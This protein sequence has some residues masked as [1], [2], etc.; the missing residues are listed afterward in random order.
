MRTAKILAFLMVVC[1]VPACGTERAESSSAATPAAEVPQANPAAEEAP[2]PSAAYAIHEW[3]F[4]A[5]HYA[6]DE[7]A[8]L[9]TSTAPAAEERQPTPQLSPG[10][11][12][13]HAGGKPVLYVHLLGE[14]E[15]AHF[16]AS[17][18]TAGRFVEEWPESENSTPT[19]LSWEVEARRSACSAIGRYP[20]A[21]SPHCFGIAD[22]Y[23]EAAELAHYETQDSACLTVASSNG[24]SERLNHLFY[25]AQMPGDLPLRVSKR[26]D[27]F[28]VV[29]S[30]ALPGRLMRIRRAD[31]A[32][33]TRV[34]L[35]DAPSEG[36][37]LV[38]PSSP[39][40]PA[41]VGIA[42]LESELA[43]LGMSEDEVGA[44]MTA[45]QAE[46]FGDTAERTRVEMVGSPP[47]SLQ[48]KADALIYFAPT[49]TLDA[50]VSLA[51][52]PPPA[53]VRR[54]ILVRVD[55][56]EPSNAAAPAPGHNAVGHSRESLATLGSE[57]RAM[58]P[59]VSLGAGLR[60][61]EVVVE[62]D[63]PLEVVRRVIRGRVGEFRFCAERSPAPEGETT[64]DV[65]VD[66]QPEGRVRNAVVQNGPRELVACVQG[67][68]RRLRF[69]ASES[70]A[71]VTLPL[72]YQ[73]PR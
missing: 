59:L 25:R 16:T 72:H 49:T 67:V 66:V 71:Q 1:G 43:A 58:A 11:I 42:A 17:L 6:D 21:G 68:A 53:E 24:A 7:S 19:R 12:I 57:A 47:M 73:F 5:H 32:S 28:S 38:L 61:G 40:Q 46:L 10:R 20:V 8:P 9:T 33:A 35:F 50:M 13:E 30:D 36:E 44:F 63:L 65:R 31:D 52:T 39:D 54:A 55:L 70:G 48:P 41:S 14:G 26:G 22:A 60:P 34:A 15:V 18:S 29:N 4:I 69:P 62:G 56:G 23:C 64:L 37:S 3:G 27:A 51:F 2:A 45:W